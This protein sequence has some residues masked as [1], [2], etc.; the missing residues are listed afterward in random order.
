M[1]KRAEARENAARLFQGCQLLRQD[2]K[3]GY[4]PKCDAKIGLKWRIAFAREW[5]QLAG[6]ML[7]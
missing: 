6:R 5:L 2:L 1:T 7:P 4:L 3:Q